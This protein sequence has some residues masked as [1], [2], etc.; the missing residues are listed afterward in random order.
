MKKLFRKL[1]GGKNRES[2]ADPRVSLKEALEPAD[3]NSYPIPRPST[4]KSPHLDS[5][6]DQDN[7]QTFGGFNQW[8]SSFEPDPH[9]VGITE[10]QDA[11]ATQRV[12]KLEGFPEYDDF[13]LTIHNVRARNTKESQTVTISGPWYMTLKQVNH[14]LAENGYEDLA[15]AKNIQ[16]E[17]TWDG[18][19]THPNEYH[20]PV[21]YGS[22]CYDPN[23]GLRIN[24]D[25]P[26]DSFL[27]HVRRIQV[28]CKGGK[29]V[30][31]SY[32]AV[33]EID[34]N[35]TL[36][37]PELN[38][39]HDQPSGLGSIH[40]NSMSAVTKRLLAS[41]NE[42]LIDM[43]KKGGVFFPLYQREAVYMS[44]N[45]SQD[46]FAVRVFVGG[47]NAVSGLTWNNPPRKQDYL[48]IPP[49]SRLDG[50][51]MGEEMVR[52]FVAMPLG[53]GYSVEK[54][55]T[56][57][58][59]IG[60]L[61]LEITPGNRWHLRP[62]GSELPDAR[63]T[64]TPKN[65]D[66][67][68]MEFVPEPPNAAVTESELLDERPVY[69][70]HL[71]LHQI[72]DPI[73]SQYGKQ[74]FHLLGYIPWGPGAEVQMIAVYKLALTIVWSEKGRQLTTNV[75]WYPWW[76][77]SDCELERSEAGFRA[78]GYDLKDCALFLGGPDGRL[79]VNKRESSLEGQGVRD[80]D[81]I[82]IRQKELYKPQFKYGYHE[83]TAA[84]GG[85][86]ATHQSRPYEVSELSGPTE[87][88]EGMP[89]GVPLMETQAWQNPASPPAKPA[90]PVQLRPYTE[91]ATTGQAPPQAYSKYDSYQYQTP[92]SRYP[93]AAYPEASDA[94]SKAQVMAPAPQQPY[95]NPY[96]P[97]QALAGV[98]SAPK[99]YDS[100]SQDMYSVSPPSTTPLGYAPIAS[101]FSPSNQTSPTSPTMGMP[102]PYSTS[103]TSVVPTSPKSHSYSS[104]GRET[105]QSVASS[106]S[107][108]SQ[109]ERP[110]GWAMGIAAGA[111]IRQKILRDTLPYDSWAKQRSTLLSVQILNSVAF[112]ALTGMMT[113]PTPITAETYRDYGFP[114]HASWGEEVVTEGA[115]N[116][117]QIQSIGE[118]DMTGEPIR[119]GSSLARGSKVA[120][121]MCRRNLC[122]TILRPCN[123][124]FCSTCIRY[125]MVYS[126]DVYCRMCNIK[127]S[128]ILGISGP[129]AL[130]GQDTVDFSNN[131][132]LTL[133][134]D[135]GL[136]AFRS[137]QELDA[138]PTPIHS[139]NVSF[140][141]QA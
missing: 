41:Q 85:Y 29:L 55:V 9:E 90:K 103:A 123:H 30:A 80:G 4:P 98:D 119:I 110:V 68:F 34:F 122:D 128:Q 113:P 121:T 112:E 52:Q 64:D 31:R 16:A 99:Y 104:P 91:N 77:L 129:M 49:Q 38:S 59:T 66:A 134:P 19:D 86:Y 43:A 7:L 109:R 137:V 111:L 67:D 45:S 37:L 69:M 1:K 135:R 117:S 92:P 97:P 101:S 3:I 100:S 89:A 33:L 140:E 93:Q 35:R 120:C 50:V 75:E 10:L 127:A 11:P 21:V 130:P 48:V 133:D 32:P 88:Q 18:G 60:G 73:Y 25:E 70:K 79:L 24:Q 87:Y 15:S 141:L 108:Q 74:P 131:K 65:L 28:D 20:V 23:L 14:L 63:G 42:S 12:L 5:A 132:V 13:S 115:E 27:N 102:S 114:F 126:G 82:Y 125:H 44:F 105:R 26:L 62:K 136:W 54:Q 58:E 106:V 81:R 124:S 84:I 96:P 118:I 46:V 53:T 57:K 83:N 8:L 116:L 76:R 36:R 78:G 51:A 139:T 72:P 61:Q 56:G 47:V 39:I 71:Y 6:D 94:Y 40:I 22:S 138:N 95:S 107:T 2:P 17:D